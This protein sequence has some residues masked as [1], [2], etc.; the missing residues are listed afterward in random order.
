MDDRTVIG[1]AAAILDAVAGHDH[2]VTL[3]ELTAAV[4]MPK[5]T[6]RR[7]AADLVARRYLERGADGYRLGA[8]L[9]ELGVRVA[10]QHG[11]R[12][13]AVPHLQD[14]FARTGEIAWVITFTTN[15]FTIVD[16][17]YG[18]SRAEDIAR[19][20]WPSD[21]RSTAVLASAAGRVLAAESPEL[22]ASLRSQRLRRFTSATVASWNRM[23]EILKDVRDTGVAI[24]QDQLGAGYGC[25]ATA[26]R[27]GYGTAVGII[28]VTGRTGGFQPIRLSHALQTA[29]DDIGQRLTGPE[30]R[31]PVP[32]SRAEPPA[33]RV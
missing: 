27:D 2:P 16:A 19:R 31:Q 15:T 23:E 33:F 5:P 25:I 11:L 10:E 4:G 32:L 12:I 1:R 22:L 24:E 13:A 8:H 14:L 6:V 28:G 7:I 30:T 21:L 29:A 9:L 17:A 26:L 20:G 18:R 3:A